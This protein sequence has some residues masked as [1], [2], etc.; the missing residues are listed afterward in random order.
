[1]KV[2]IK[3]AGL[4]GV[5][6]MPS[7]KSAM[8]RALALA[9]LHQGE[10]II[11]Q[12]GFSNDDKAAMEII[13]ALGA[14]IKIISNAEIHITGS[15]F[16]HQPAAVQLPTA[17]IAI[18]CGESG[19]ALRMFTPIAAL[20]P[21]LI[22]IKGSGSL[23]KRPVDFFQELLPQLQINVETQKGFPPILLKGK[24][25][26]LPIEIDGSLSSQF[27]T[28][29]LIA[30]AFATK[31]E[32]QIIVHQLKSKPYINL[33]LA[34]L[35]IFGYRVT[36]QNLSTF[37]IMPSSASPEIISYKVEADWSAASF[38]LVAA[39][40]NGNILVKGLSVHSTQADTAI[41]LALSRAGVAVMDATD[42]IMVKKSVL[43][44]FEFDATDC[45]D[46]FP[47]LVALAAYCKGVTKIKGVHRLTHKESNRAITLQLEFLKLG[48]EIILH[49]DEMWIYG[50][51][52]INSAEVFAHNDHRI[53]MALAV[54]AIQ[55]NGP[56]MI[57]Q[58]E[59]INKSY[60]L[61]YEDLKSLGANLEEI[62]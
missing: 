3:P 48:I 7:S 55:A 59:A 35:K 47:P 54:A 20:L 60:P 37:T 17:P 43:K 23:M 52:N 58:A 5:L 24:F 12:P 22:Y 40:I 13:E 38:L 15:S 33:T 10:T 25:T 61:F 16:Y 34:M 62:K 46:L 31:K 8:Q 49:D 44:P 30:F 45:P 21:N 53:A 32:V 11:Y 18:N 26:P 4:N 14:K 42:G 39:A 19:L 2:C 28:G 27:L 50:T 36:H 6:Q 29:L 41:L 1:M 56:V 57:L 51:G 9:L